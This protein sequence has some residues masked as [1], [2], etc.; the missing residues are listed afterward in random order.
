MAPA[1]PSPESGTAPQ[2]EGGAYE[3]IRARMDAAAADLRS[4]LEQL[5]QERLAV[6]GGVET[7][8][9]ATERVGTE[10]NCQAR[11]L[12]AIG[13]SRFLFGY[14]IQFGL[15]ATTE[16]TDV[17]SVYDFNAESNTFAAVPAQEVIGEP[18]FADDFAYLYKF[19]R[20]TKFKKFHIIG[21]HLFMVMLAG[22]TLDDIK[23]FKWRM[24]GDNTLEYL[25]N[26]F[27]HE[28]VYPRQQEFE[29]TRARRDMQRG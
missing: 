26:R 22:K 17:F 14:N 5:N 11:D 13:P 20:E 21:P 28:Y 7:K 23:V 3:V 18:S 24:R 6:F 8:L 19:Y 27:D 9:L 10:H 16:I 25:G 1:P 12:V 29:W 15:K 2:L 4:R